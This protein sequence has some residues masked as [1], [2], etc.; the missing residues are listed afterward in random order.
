M[1]KQ[2][3]DRHRK[4][5]FDFCPCS[6]EASMKDPDDLEDYEEYNEEPEE[7]DKGEEE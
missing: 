2:I 4:N 7:E 3:D 6:F 1:S 5:R